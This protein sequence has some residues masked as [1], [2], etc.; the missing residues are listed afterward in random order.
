MPGPVALIKAFLIPLHNA[1]EAQNNAH[2]DDAQ[3]QSV[4]LI[5]LANELVEQQSDKKRE[6][7]G[8]DTVDNIVQ[9]DGGVDQS[10]GTPR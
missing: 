5:A 9:K 8:H 4:H 6:H 2:D 10:S 7:L 3:Q 1:K